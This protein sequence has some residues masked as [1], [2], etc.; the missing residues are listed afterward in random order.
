MFEELVKALSNFETIF[1]AAGIAFLLLSLCDQIKIKNVELFING[2]KAFV[3]FIIGVLFVAGSISVAISSPI[4]KYFEVNISI[5]PYKD[6]H[7]TSSV[8]TDFC[9]SKGY[10]T[11]MWNGKGS[12]PTFGVICIK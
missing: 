6:F 1:V 10:K 12:G 8:V 3:A 2:T 4:T 9:G 5:D 11:G 7:D